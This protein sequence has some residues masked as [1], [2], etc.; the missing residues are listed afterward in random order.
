VSS[1]RDETMG[2]LGYASAADAAGIYAFYLSISSGAETSVFLLGG[3]VEI[4][5]VPSSRCA[6]DFRT[7]VRLQLV[8]LKNG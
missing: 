1:E 6:F 3:L 7:A 4:G 2:K 5:E 8:Y